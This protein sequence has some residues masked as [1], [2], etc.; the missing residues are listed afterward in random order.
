MQEPV[1]EVLFSSVMEVCIRIRRLYRLTEIM[2]KYEKQGGLPTLNAPAYG[3][4]IKAYGRARDVERVWAIW[5]ERR[6]RGVD[7]SAIAVGC[8]VHALVKSG[9]V[10]EAWKLVQDLGT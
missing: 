2:Q 5:R 9:E 8:T 4:M 10:D 6:S 1:D 7:P 3:S